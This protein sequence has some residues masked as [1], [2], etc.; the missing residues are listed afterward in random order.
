MLIRMR[1]T[2][3]AGIYTLGRT[4]R[5]LTNGR[6]DLWKQLMAWAALWIMRCGKKD[7]FVLHFILDSF[8]LV[9]F[10]LME[11]DTCMAPAR[12]NLSTSSVSRTSGI[13]AERVHRNGLWA[14]PAPDASCDVSPRLGLGQSPREEIHSTRTSGGR[15]SC[16]HR[17]PH[18][19]TF[20]LFL[21]FTN[22]YIFYKKDTVSSRRSHAH[23][24]SHSYHRNALSLECT[25]TFSWRLKPPK[26]LLLAHFILF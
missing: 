9:Y 22:I 3:A 20:A 17:T 4:K 21:S 19:P 26:C 13:R 6:H 1:E 12:K 7:L 24:H 15:P 14:G 8:L 11:H 23:R 25:N 10:F 16:V 2:L 18:F 5:I